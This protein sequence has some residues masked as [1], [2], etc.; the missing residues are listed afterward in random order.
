MGQPDILG[1]A[2]VDTVEFS[3]DVALAACAASAGR[4]P[5]AAGRRRRSTVIAVYRFVGSISAFSDGGGAGAAI[6]AAA[7]PACGRHR[8]GHPSVG[9]PYFRSRAKDPFRRQRYC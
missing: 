7:G 5:I 9:D 3:A 4:A 8:S 2:E 1:A 6:G